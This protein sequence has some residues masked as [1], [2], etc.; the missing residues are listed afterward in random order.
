MTDMSKEMARTLT[1]EQKDEIADSLYSYFCDAPDGHFIPMEVRVIKEAL[2]L[3]ME[4]M[5]GV[6]DFNNT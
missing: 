3:Y 2:A 4:K 6:G 1:N 5:K